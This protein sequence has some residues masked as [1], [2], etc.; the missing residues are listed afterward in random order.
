[1]TNA[2]VLSLTP[3]CEKS[4]PEQLDPTALFGRFP[5]PQALASLKLKPVV[6]YRGCTIDF[7]SDA[8]QLDELSMGLCPISDLRIRFAESPFKD[9]LKLYCLMALSYGSLAETT[10]IEDVRSIQKDLLSIGK[11]GL[12][13]S[14]IDALKAHFES[15]ASPYHQMARSKARL[16]AFLTFRRVHFGKA[17]AKEVI[18]YLDE[19][20]GARMRASREAGK[21]DE[22]PYDYLCRLIDVCLERMRDEGY[23]MRLR[24]MA[25]AVLIYS[26]VGMRTSQLLGAKVGAL[27]THPAPVGDGAP[28][29]YLE[30]P[31]IKRKGKSRKKKVQKS[32][33]NEIVVE[34]YEFLV[35]ACA[36]QRERL[37]IEALV[38]LPKQKCKQL[39]NKQIG[40]LLR[41]LIVANSDRLP[42]VNT[43]DE[44]PGLKT[45]TTPKTQAGKANTGDLAPDDVIVYPTIHQLRVSVCTLLYERGVD[46]RY[47]KEHMGHLSEDMTAYYIRSNKRIDHECSELVYDCIYSDGSKLL[48]KKAD[49]FVER[50]DEFI[51]EMSGGTACST[52]DAI[53]MASEEFPLRKKVGGWCC[54]CG[55]VVQ[56][57]ENK[58]TDE[59]LCAFGLCP[60]HCHMYFMAAQSYSVAKQLE[61]AASE[62]RS[63][64]HHKAAACEERKLANVTESTLMPELVELGN[65]IE[66]RGLSDVLS[67]FPELTDIATRLPE[68]MEEARS[69]QR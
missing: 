32:I 22:V 4:V 40:N 59:I 37:G 19:R 30:F 10:I 44:Y 56:C 27:K 23:P 39:D 29:C 18:A 14:S 42:C 69:W 35:E 50:V 48:G 45:T 28:V 65:E 49:E 5:G 68:I 58:V 62:N 17:T 55:L 3:A 61:R 63:R 25:A 33:A 2:A 66:R 64:G 24:I 13:P 31:A 1:M 6:D 41:I 12:R 26:Q 15:K 9:E 36:P 11:D 34:A 21:M 51:R 47:V 43:Q 60:N 52:D 57:P 38:V 7:G 67:K 16:S 53:R 20:D 54:R 8:W 46:L